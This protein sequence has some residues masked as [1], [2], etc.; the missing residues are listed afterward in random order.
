[1]S[2]PIVL[3][4]FKLILIISYLSLNAT[5]QTFN[6]Y[7]F[8]YWNNLPLKINGVK[9]HNP[10]VGG[11]NNIQFGEIDLNMDGQND[12]IVFDRHGNRLLPFIFQS[13]PIPWYEYD[14]SYKKHLPPVINT[15][16]IHDYNG[17]QKPDIYTY[18]PGGIMVY[19]N[20]SQQELRFEKAVQQFI[21][22]LQGNIFTNLLVTN[23]D[24]PAIFDIDNDGDFDILTFW[25]LGSFMELHQNMSIE[26]YGHADS[27]LYHKVD[28][29]WGRFS[30][31]AESNEIVLDTCVDLTVLNP[32]QMFE[33]HGAARSLQGERHT[34]STLSL[35]DINND[36]VLDLLLGD[37]D[38]LSIK[39]LINGGNNTEALI[40]E[41]IDSFPTVNPINLSS[42]PSMQQIDVYNDGIPDLIASPFDPGLTRSAGYNSVW[43][44]NIS[45]SGEL[46]KVKES[47]LQD[48]MIDV[49]LGGYPVFAEITDDT[50]TDLVVGNYGRLLSNYYDDNGQLHCEYSSSISL[51]KNIGTAANPEFGLISDDFGGLLSQEFLSAYPAFGDLNGDQ[52]KDMLIGTADGQLLLFYNNGFIN[53][54]P[55]YEA[56]V[57]LS[58]EN[59][60]DYLTPTFIDINSDGLLDILCGNKVGKLDLLINIGSVQLPDFSLVTNDFGKINVADSTQSYTGYSVPAIFTDKQNHLRLIVGSESGN[61]AY[62][63]LVSSDPFEELLPKM[64][65][66]NEISEGIRTS[67]SISDLDHDGFP[68]LAVGNY[69]G[70]I[71][72]RKGTLAG[73]SDIEENKYA[74]QSLKIYPNPVNSTA[75]VYLSADGDWELAI[76]NYSG[77]LMYQSLF[78]GSTLQIDLNNLRSGLYLIVA[79]QKDKSRRIL[80]GKIMITR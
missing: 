12:L 30:E 79:S 36:N 34:G 76:Y 67:C 46:T 62:Y 52:L 53:D 20:I 10:W 66:F 33:L 13:L 38:F 73:P 47:F 63:P 49:G 77:Q 70:G 31:D 56:P 32:G 18:T 48:E 39:A 19:K 61:L 55:V 11:L 78:S 24:Y 7:G 28:Y 40:T 58:T 64:D 44:F 8:A 42:F 26:T 14:P 9:I 60:G 69:S 43:Q 65:A 74:R 1:M 71:S 2:S 6:D 57:N 80:T 3:Y 41:V 25:G 59:L 27:L 4:R 35:L 21:T 29:C 51:F 16:Q 50:L 54:L 37:V 22:S 5:A 68:D 72:L 17:D 23:V 15:F 45:E 75:T